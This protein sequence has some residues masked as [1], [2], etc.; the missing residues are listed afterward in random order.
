MESLKEID[1]GPD[2]AAPLVAEH[3]LL[4]LNGLHLDMKTSFRMHLG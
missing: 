4:D 1:T 3:R 2:S